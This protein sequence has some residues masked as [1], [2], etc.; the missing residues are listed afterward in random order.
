MTRAIHFRKALP[1]VHT[2]LALFFGGAGLFLRDALLNRPFLSNPAVYEPTLRSFIWPWPLKFAAILDMPAVL[3]GILLSYA[4]DQIDQ[5]RPALPAWASVLSMLVF[6]PLLWFAVGAWL[7]RTLRAR[8]RLEPLSPLHSH[9]R[10]SRRNSSN[11]HCF[12]RKL[13]RLRRSPL[14]SASHGHRR[15]RPPPVDQTRATEHALEQNRI[16]LP[17]R[18]VKIGP[19]AY[20]EKKPTA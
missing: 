18:F 2:I 9:L 20:A 13:R 5:L 10:N 7:D 11:H 3:A 16:H 15:P 12:R 17:S 1:I 4:L 6:V 19:S 14:A 8:H